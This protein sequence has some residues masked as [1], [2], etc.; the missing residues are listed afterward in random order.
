MNFEEN[1]WRR[2]IELVFLLMFEPLRLISL[3]KGLGLPALIFVAKSLTL[4]T[5]S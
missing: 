1:E 4:E 2:G 3:E 5:A